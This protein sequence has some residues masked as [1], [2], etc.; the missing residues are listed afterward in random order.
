MDHKKATAKQTLGFTMLSACCVSTDLD[1]YG[2]IEKLSTKDGFCRHLKNVLKI[3]SISVG[4][5]IKII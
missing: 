3:A 2:Y 4:R 1:M 5:H